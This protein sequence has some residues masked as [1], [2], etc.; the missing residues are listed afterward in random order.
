MI[1]I[2]GGTTE[3]SAL[4][5]LLAGRSD[6]PA[7]LSL[8]G[9]TMNP[10]AQPIP[11]RVG[12][13]GGATGLADFFAAKGVRAVID[14]THPF[15]GQI[16]ANAA[17]ACAETDTPLLVLRRHP[18]SPQPGDA[19]TEVADA[20]AAAEALGR[21]PVRVF[22]TVGRLELPTFL[23]FPQHH[24]VIRTIDP[25][26]ALPPDSRLILDRGPFDEAAE[27]A[28]LAQ[29]KIEVLVTKNSGGT[30]TYA[31]IAAARALGLPVILMRPPDW[32][33]ATCVDTPEAALAWIKGLGKQD[34]AR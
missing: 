32:P 5:R 31:K 17:L 21:K 16:S 2:L 1:L 34:K 7:L 9:R 28:L 13:F 20:Q 27:R 18:W 14:A 29:E 11:T 30:A 12:G 19:W 15:A 10:G 6:M 4:A 25:P 8:A 24:Y 23:D 22:L 3:A 26:E 33:D